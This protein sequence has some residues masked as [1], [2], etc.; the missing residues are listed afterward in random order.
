[1]RNNKGFSLVEVLITVVIISFIGG[2]LYSTLSQGLKLWSRANQ[3]TP[4]LDVEI[5]FE[6]MGNDM[7]NAFVFNNKPFQGDSDSVEFGSLQKRIGR[8]QNQ[9]FFQGAPAFLKYYYDA[10]T[11]A[12]LRDVE[13]YQQ[14]LKPDK[15]KVV[16]NSMLNNVVDYNMVYY[17]SGRDGEIPGW[18]GRWLENCF[19]SAVKVS[20]QVEGDKRVSI[21]RIIDIP[22]KHC[23]GSTT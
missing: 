17:A 4:E 14:L 19:P 7:R 23:G 22:T 12:V 8:A 18:R 11:K 9:S 10:R 20:V 21:S 3:S 1:M 16:V 15:D 5:F 6:K 2:V 13:E